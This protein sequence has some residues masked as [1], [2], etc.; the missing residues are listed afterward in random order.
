MSSVI[1]RN[2]FNKIKGYIDYARHAHDAEIIAGSE[3]KQIHMLTRSRNLH[4]PVTGFFLGNDSVGYY[5]QPTIIVTTNPQFKTLT[6]EVFG[7]VLT[8][9]VYPANEF[10]ATVGPNERYL[11]PSLFI[12]HLYRWNWPIKPVPIV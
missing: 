4:R 3:C 11:A 5:I 8:I 2:A 12:I 7:P 9:Y 1:D 10:E 6:E